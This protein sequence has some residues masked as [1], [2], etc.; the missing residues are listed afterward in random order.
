VHLT[1]REFAI[2][3]LLAA[4]AGEPITAAQ[5]LSKVWGAGQAVT[6][7]AVR[8]HIASLRKKLSPTPP[9]PATLSPSL[10]GLPLH[11]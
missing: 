10:G 1:P 3:E 9:T 2:L 4:H 8:V 7:D 11:R 6:P 5:I